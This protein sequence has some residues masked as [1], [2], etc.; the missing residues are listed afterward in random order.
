[1]KL[2]YLTKLLIVLLPVLIF[3]HTRG[4]VLH[5]EGYIIFSA[6]KILQG[7]LPYRDFDFVYTPGSILL[8]AL[9]FTIFHP[10]VLASRIL[11]ILL[12][13]LSSLLIFK[14]VILPTKNK[15]YATLATLLFIA[16]GP[17]HLNFAWP[18]MFSL[19]MGLLTCYLLLK[20]LETRK[21]YYLFLAGL[22]AFGVFITKQNFGVAILLPVIIF[23]LTKSSRNILYIYKFIL[24]YA[25][26][27]ILLATYLLATESFS[28]FIHNFYFYTFRWIL[29]YQSLTTPF[30]YPDIPVKMIAR[31]GV[32]LF[33]PGISIVS[34]VVLY[35]RRRFHLLF[36]PLFVLSYYLFGIRPT[37]DYVHIVPLLALTGIPL[38]LYLRYNI[39]TNIRIFLFLTISFLIFSGFYTA[40]YKGYYRWD[41]P[42]ITHTHYSGEKVKI[43]LNEKFKNEFIQFSDITKAYVN[44][45]DYI[46]VDSFNPM[47]YFITNTMDPMKRGYLGSGINN[48]EYYGEVIG[49][50][51]GKR[52]KVVILA[53]NGLQNHPIKSFIIDNYTYLKTVQDFDVYVTKP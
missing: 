29:E 10:S 52:I 46:Y 3:F 8:T 31:T 24:G 20:F 13:L 37:T 30:L 9:S 49:N 44:I 47:L 2:P 36:L 34:F 5:D 23:F 17:S 16:W 25:W 1:M 53:H 39:S 50:L 6:E 14:I 33:V 12:S 11:M 7:L 28:Q 27:I 22:G 15:L 41:A 26:G 32:Y 51:V 43:F 19:P 35:I 42:L 21:D 40:L 45:G 4:V 48:K 18:V 38:G